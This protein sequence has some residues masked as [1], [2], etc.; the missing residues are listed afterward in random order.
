MPSS[1]II[2]VVCADLATGF[3]LVFPLPLLDSSQEEPNNHLLT[4][5]FI[6]IE[7]AVAPLLD[8]V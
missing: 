4:P 2:H 6:Q 3:S 7:T 1:S 8:L 5:R